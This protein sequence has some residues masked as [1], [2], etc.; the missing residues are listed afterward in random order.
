MLKDCSTRTRLVQILRLSILRPLMSS[1]HF[2]VVLIRSAIY[3]VP[4][5][6]CVIRAEHLLGLARASLAATV[7]R[8][9]AAV[10][11]RRRVMCAGLTRCARLLSPAL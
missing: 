8:A 1:V 4:R 5:G 10:L 2:D 11:S 3:A 6:T 7:S 9:V